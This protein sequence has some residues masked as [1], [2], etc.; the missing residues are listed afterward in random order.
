MHHPDAIYARKVSKEKLN[1]GPA[2][3]NQRRRP[4]EVGRAKNLRGPLATSDQ[5]PDV[6]SMLSIYAHF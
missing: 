5:I 6:D 1:V 4:A 2:Y 3:P